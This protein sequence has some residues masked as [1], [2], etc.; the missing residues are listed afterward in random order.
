MDTEWASAQGMDLRHGRVFDQLLKDVGSD[1]PGSAGNHDS[2]T[3]LRLTY[4][5][6]IEGRFLKRV[7]HALS[8]GVALGIGSTRAE[9]TA[10]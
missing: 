9:R 6:H 1:K 3:Y 10:G 7:L 2:T 4:V 5:R 8:R